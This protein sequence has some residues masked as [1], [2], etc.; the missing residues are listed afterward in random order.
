MR[1][2]S[3]AIGPYKN[4]CAG[5][6]NPGA[7]GGNY[8]M[9]LALGT[10]TVKKQ[11]SHSGSIML[12]QTLAFDAAEISGVNLGQTNM[13][14][15]SS[16]CGPHGSVWGYHLAKQQPQAHPLFPLSTYSYHGQKVP[17][18]SASPYIQAAKSLL[19]TINKKVFPI[20]PGSHVPCATKS[21][22]LEGPTL[23]YSAI[24]M[25]VP[26]TEDVDACL[27]M[28]DVGQF[29]IPLSPKDFMN[30]KTLVL[31]NMIKS[32]I[33]VGINQHVTYREIVIEIIVNN[34][35]NNEIGCALVAAPYLTLAKNAIP[36]GGINRLFKM[37]LQEWQN[38]IQ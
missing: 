37:T 10:G 26:I 23:L 17:V 6:E 22:M 8:L 16:F 34:V 1:T 11:L 38:S 21:I 20:K 25:G 33:S 35:A 15:V 12:D 2:L 36:K 27:M 30:A 19:G 14:T 31:E 3:G 24:G 7:S 5:Y 32:I 29:K 18:F 28:E 4:Y 13:I 9:V